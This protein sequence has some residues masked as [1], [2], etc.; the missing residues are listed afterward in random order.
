LV[1]PRSEVAAII[2]PVDFFGG[3]DAETLPEFYMRVSERLRHK[4]RGVTAWDIEHLILAQF[5]AIKETRCITANAHPNIAP[6]TMTVVVVP[7][8]PDTVLE[9]SVSFHQ[10]EEIRHF[11]DQRTSSFAKVR[12]INPDYER[13]KISCAIRLKPG[14]E[15]EAGWYARHLHEELLH[16]ICPWLKKGRV[17]FGE[18]LSRNDVITFITNRPYVQFVTRLSLV[19]IFKPSE[20]HTEIQDTAHGDQS[21]ET[22]R[23]ETPW[24]VFVPVAQHNITFLSYDKSLPPE[25]TAIEAMRL[26]TDFVVGG[27]SDDSSEGADSPGGG[28]YSSTDLSDADDDWFI[29]KA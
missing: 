22:L 23:P 29:L 12:V 5:P 18:G 19:K 11:I 1:V 6:G 25:V 2:Q 10:S 9:P 21:L 7:F 26:G 24:S 8:A 17:S 20:Y 4:N 28:L 14:L 3:N 27:Y 13:I 15:Q 16:F